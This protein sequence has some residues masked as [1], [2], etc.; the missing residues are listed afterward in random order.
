MALSGQHMNPATATLLSLLLL[1]CG[2]IECNPGPLK[3]I[4]AF[5]C[6]INSLYANND[7][8]KLGELET[9]AAITKSDII[10]LTETWL[11]SSIPDQLL[12]IAGFLPPIRNDR[13]RHGGGVLIYC[14]D[15]L[16]VVPRPDLSTAPYESTWVEIKHKPNEKILIGVFYRPPNQRAADRDQFLL[17]LNQVVS[18]VI[19]ENP[20]SVLIMGDFNDRCTEWNGSHFT[21]ELGT[22]LYEMVADNG[23]TQIIDS[24]THLDNAGRPQHLLDLLITDSPD[25]ILDSQVLP[26]IGSCKHC[27]TFCKLAISLPKDKPFK[28]TVWDFNNVDII[29]LTDALTAAPWNTAYELYDDVDDIEHFWNQLFLETAR[30]Y[31]PTRTITVHPHTKPWMTK[32]LRL[33][34]NKKHRLWHRYKKTQRPEHLDIYRLVRNQ[35]VREVIKSKS[36]YFNSLIPTLQN[37]NQDPKK[38]WRITKSLLHNKT[39]TSIPPLFED[40]AV[41]TDAAHK[42][43]IFNTYFSGNSRL[44]PHADSHPL[45]PFEFLTNQRL[46]TLSVTSHEVYNVLVGLNVSKATGPDNIGNFLLK[47]CAG[48]IS[49]SVAKLFNHSLETQKFPTKWKFSNVVP[50]HKKSS[51]NEKAN[52]RPISLLCNI[53]KAMERLV[54]NKMY[55]YLTSNSLLT[56]LNSGFKKHDSATNQLIALHNN[57]CKS[58]EQKHDVRVVFLDLSKAFDRVWHKGLIFKLKQLGITGPLLNWLQNYLSGRH[59]RVVID[60]QASDWMKIEAGVPQGSILGPLL[61]IIFINDII[62][63]IQSNIRLFADDISMFHS[64]VDSYLTQQIMNHDLHKIS[65]WATQWLM[66]F[67]ALK[68]EAMTLSLRTTPIPQP[69]LSFDG[70]QLKEVKEHTHLGLTLS[71]NMSWKPHVDRICSRAGQRNNILRKLKFRLPRK[72]LENL[73]KSLVRPMLEYGDIVFDD[74]STTLSQRLEA[75]QVDAARTCTG[76]FISTSTNLLLSELGWSTLTERRKTHKL[77]YYYK[78]VNGLTPHYLHDLL[79][80]R[81]A[82]ISNYPLRNALNRSLVPARTMRYKQSFLP[83]TTVLWNT[84]PDSVRVSATLSTFKK[85]L[86]NI[87][88]PPSP[89]HW[90]YTGS[91]YANILHTRLRVNNPA[92]NAYLFRSGRSPICSCNCGHRLENIKHFILECPQYAVQRGRLL[93]DIQNLFTFELPPDT[94]LLSILLHGSDEHDINT[95]ISVCNIFQTFIISTGRFLLNN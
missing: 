35:T 76:A 44:P 7:D 79:P 31:I 53:S 49:N 14:A 74:N 93:A 60:G 63:D 80:P 81:V 2:D 42:A 57:I 85:S 9:L 92:L 5:Q 87:K 89:P 33:L 12:S 43:E 83:S 90:R 56:P 71:S 39:Q 40:N 25:L 84:L 45:P 21:S 59:Q 4:S 38:W 24:P 16:P 23:L 20:K 75:I 77:I 18:A 27:P 26:P 61:F 58:L 95:N 94:R 69:P 17:H 32:T 62:K 72:T 54:H 29:S 55:D 6:N 15:H 91:R 1:L 13:N 78:I 51:R 47:I 86:N 68:N 88:Q 82:D 70:I 28:R 11:D 22:K 46:A 10:A 66:T 30:Q 65:E 48:A 64:I 73:Y 52:Y 41:I 37:P 67:N 19:Q 34:I 3:S 50:V 36:H 8:H